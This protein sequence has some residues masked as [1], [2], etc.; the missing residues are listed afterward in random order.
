MKAYRQNQS[1]NQRRELRDKHKL[2]QEC[3]AIARKCA[4]EGVGPLRIDYA[5]KLSSIKPETLASI[6]SALRSKW[7]L[8]AVGRCALDL[9][10]HEDEYWQGDEPLPGMDEGK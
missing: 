3:F 6:N 8:D 1:K 7:G 9:P 10:E 4:V 2:R 5:G